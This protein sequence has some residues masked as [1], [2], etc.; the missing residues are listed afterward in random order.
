[1]AQVYH[2][3]VLYRLTERRVDSGEDIEWLRVMRFYLE[4]EVSGGM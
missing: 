3:D 4:G 2:R 1:V